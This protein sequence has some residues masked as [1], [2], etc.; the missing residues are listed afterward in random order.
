VWTL[1]GAIDP[2]DLGR[3]TSATL[4][5]PR[6]LDVAGAL[7]LATGEA[8]VL[9]HVRDGEDIVRA[10][11]GRYPNY[12][13][14][15]GSARYQGPRRRPARRR[16]PGRRGRGHLRERGDRAGARQRRR[17]TGCT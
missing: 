15:P 6:A 4:T 7:L 14:V 13:P 10:V 5:S 2:R 16:R 12:L 11:A 9:E 3:L 17:A 1:A 8:G